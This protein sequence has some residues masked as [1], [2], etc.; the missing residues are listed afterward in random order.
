MKDNK[1]YEIS[2]P[3][4]ADRYQ[5]T[6]VVR[7]LHRVM[8][9]LEENLVKKN[10]DFESEIGL[11]VERG[12]EDEAPLIFLHFD[13]RRLY[14]KDSLHGIYKMS[15]GYTEEEITQEL[16]ELYQG[17]GKCLNKEEL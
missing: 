3:I 14:E 4:I 6:M 11:T 1:C 5:A 7:V 8:K 10:S 12:F 13:G 2:I 9:Y 17:L 15:S 16:K